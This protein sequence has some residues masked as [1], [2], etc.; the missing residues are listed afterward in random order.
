MNATRGLLLGGALGIA[1]LGL[2]WAQEE[3]MLK[4]YPQSATT[5][6]STVQETVPTTH[7]DAVKPARKSVMSTLFW[8][9][10]A[11][12]ASNE[13][14]PNDG[15]FWDQDWQKHYGGVDDPNCRTAFNPCGF[16]PKENPFYVALPYADFTESGKLQENVSIVPWYRGALADKQS[17][18][19]NHWVEVTHAGHTCYA[20]WED[21]GPFVYDDVAYVFG[22][23]HP[24]NTKNNGAGLDLS[25]AM[26]SCLNMTDNDYTSWR[27]VGN[28]EVPDGPWRAVI[29]TRGINWY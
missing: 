20:Q 19:K 24:Q 17:A 18:V 28:S 2:L 15:S 10:E 27:F 13:N 23:S 5:A 3:G 8:V 21:A 6:T 11:A 12:D 1:L 29:T 9:G 26:W 14:I 25:P 4:A 22:N 16:T 7:P